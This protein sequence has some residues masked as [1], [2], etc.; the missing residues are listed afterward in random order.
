VKNSEFLISKI[1]SAIDAFSDVGIYVFASSG[2]LGVAALMLS[3]DLIL[4]ESIKS[5]NWPFL[6]LVTGIIAVAF[7]VVLRVIRESY[8][9]NL[10]LLGKWRIGVFVQAEKIDLLAPDRVRTIDQF[11]DNTFSDLGFRSAEDEYNEANRRFENLLQNLLSAVVVKYRAAS[12]P[13]LALSEPPPP[14]P[15]PPQ[16][17]PPI[18]KKVI[19]ICPFCAADVEVQIVNGVLPQTAKCQS[20]G[21]EYSLLITQRPPPPSDGWTPDKVDAVIKLVDTLATKAIAYKENEAAADHRSLRTVTK[22]NVVLTILL[23]VFL[24]VIIAI[25][26]YLT[27]T[28]SVSGEALLFLVGTV[29]GYIL[30]FI[31]RLAKPYIWSTDSNDQDED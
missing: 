19:Y 4:P 20:C 24:A 18:A 5:T 22:Y 12:V 27:Y 28:G 29:T 9:K 16:Q 31:Q 30:L 14:P 6:A 3:L 23:T 21:K 1:D 13:I 2:I 26:S 10:N 8:T 17:G 25:M 15:P 7:A 11:I